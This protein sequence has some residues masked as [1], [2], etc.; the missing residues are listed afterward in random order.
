[1]GMLIVSQNLPLQ[2]YTFFIIKA[3]TISIFPSFMYF[4]PSSDIDW[5]K[6]IAK[7]D[8]QLYVKE[9][10]VQLIA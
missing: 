1:M 9:I 3:S 5:S 4:F 10:M 6:S 2:R 8:A 7:I